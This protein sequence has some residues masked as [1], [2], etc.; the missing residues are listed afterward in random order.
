MQ[1]LSLCIGEG[2]VSEVG[3]LRA[4]L[5]DLD[6]FVR[7]VEN[8]HQRASVPP[9][10]A[11]VGRHALQWQALLHRVRAAMRDEGAPN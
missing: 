7:D 11:Y 1:C 8:K 5:R 3:R 10:E 4:L 9:S 2:I 6:A